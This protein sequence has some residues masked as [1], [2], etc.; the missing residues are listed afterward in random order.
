MQKILNIDIRDK[1]DS[2]YLLSIKDPASS[3]VR[4]FI[5]LRIESTNF[6]SSFKLIELFEIKHPQ[7]L[8]PFIR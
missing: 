7:K 4:K 5:K 3:V 1:N 2:M 8:L 6:K